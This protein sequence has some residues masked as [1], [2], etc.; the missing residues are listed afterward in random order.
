MM[1]L[2]VPGPNG[3]TM[4]MGLPGWKS[5]ATAGTVAAVTLAIADVMAARRDSLMSRIEFLPLMS[6]SRQ[7]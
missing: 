7:E 6:S 5:W 1:S 4:T 2:V 3:A